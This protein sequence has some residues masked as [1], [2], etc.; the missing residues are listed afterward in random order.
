MQIEK[1]LNCQARL[2]LAMLFDDGSYTEINSSAKEND[3]LTGVVTAY[4]CVNGN[5][6]Y[7]FSQDK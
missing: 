1:N 6:V 7:A 5:P 4:G 3:S 2:R